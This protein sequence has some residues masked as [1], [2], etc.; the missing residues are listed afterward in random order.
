M[1]ILIVE[2]EIYLAELLKK[3]VVRNG[4]YKRIPVKKKGYKAVGGKYKRISNSEKRKRSLSGKRTQRK[5]K[6]RQSS[7]QRKRKRSMAKRH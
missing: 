5:L 7:I 3:T 1:T 4:K 6:G 2:D